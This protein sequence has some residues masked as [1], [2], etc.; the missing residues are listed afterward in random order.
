MTSPIRVGTRGS[1]LALWQAD[2]VI[3]RLGERWPGIGTER[4]VCSTAGDRW[5][6][7]PPAATGL[8]GLFTSELE[9]ALRA[10]AIDLAVHSLKDVPT[11]AGDGVAIGAILPRADPRDALLSL[12]G[13]TL[14]TLPRAARVGTCSVRRRAQLLHARP[15]L[16][17]EDLRGN[18]PT[19]I[20]RLTQ[21]GFDGIVLAHA[22]L[23][24]L[25]LT[26]H[27]SEVLT[28]DQMLP[29]AG[30]GAIA[31]QSRAGDARIAGLL[32]AIDDRPT[33]LAVAAERALLAF[34]HGGCQVPL[35]ALGRL[36]G[37]ALAL[38]AAVAAL[39]G[40]QV[41]REALSRAVDVEG[42][43][44]EAAETLGRDLG[45]RLL[46]AGAG[47]LLDGAR[48]AGA[49]DDAPGGGAGA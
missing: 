34:L 22:G 38:R 4:V 32:S 5:A 17:V 12:A 11:A 49:Q 2:H 27:V 41:I 28:P 15:D 43:G 37:P 20:A 40:S 3:A 14:A 45:R 42:D 23:L 13:W 1:A 36:E 6:E 24:R 10:G 9:E 8:Q 18:V 16:R 19:R 35:G 26:A 31:V 47:V 21:G 30:Q 48:A 39:D 25:G 7:T 33:R 44:E 46:E 29:A